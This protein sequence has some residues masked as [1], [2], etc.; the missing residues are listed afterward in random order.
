MNMSLW[1]IFYAAPMLAF[2]NSCFF[3]LLRLL[4]RV[5]ISITAYQNV[6]TFFIYIASAPL[7]VYLAVIL[8]LVRIQLGWVHSCTDGE[9]M[10]KAFG[11][12]TSAFVLFAFARYIYFIRLPNES[13]GNAYV[14]TMTRSV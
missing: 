9:W 2:A 8:H 4:I 10:F 3:Q 14:D 7:I 1:K 5:K 13:V 12:F 6:N 11:G